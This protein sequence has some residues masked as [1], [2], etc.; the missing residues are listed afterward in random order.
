MREDRHDQYNSDILGSRSLVMT[1]LRS[2]RILMKDSNPSWHGDMS[3]FCKRDTTTSRHIIS[4]AL[5]YVLDLLRC[6]PDDLYVFAERRTGALESTKDIEG[7]P[8]R[9]HRAMTFWDPL[10]V[11]LDL[12]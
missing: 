7:L 12:Y 4:A 11:P 2:N 10:H 5:R 6:R 9:E 3:H 1:V 8:S